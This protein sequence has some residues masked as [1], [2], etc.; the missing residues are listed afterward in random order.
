MAQWRGTNARANPRSDQ[1]L[2]GHMAGRFWALSL[3][4][5]HRAPAA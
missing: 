5:Q 4:W 3:G 2:D 1:L